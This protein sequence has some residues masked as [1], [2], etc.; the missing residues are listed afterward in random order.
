MRILVLAGGASREREISLRSGKAVASA[1]GSLG[2]EVGMGDP[3][4]SV[5][6]FLPALKLRPDVL[7]NVLH[8]GEGENGVA[9]DACERLGVPYT[10]S[11]PEGSRLGMDKP[12]AKALF[13]EAGLLT[14]DWEAV[15]SCAIDGY[16]PPFPL[17]IVVKPAASG[18]SIGVSIVGSVSLLP[19][20]LGR[21]A[22]ED[23]RVLVEQF[24]PGR[25]ITVGLLDFEPLP[26]VEV[27]PGSE[28][29]DYDAKYSSK[30][31]RYVC[32]APLASEESDQATRAAVAAARA[33]CADGAVRVDMILNENAQVW[34]LEVNT[35]PGM[36]ERSLLP[37]AA[38]AAGLDFPALCARMVDMACKRAGR[39]QGDRRA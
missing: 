27:V 17:P 3:G 15:P 10:G 21:A 5:E 7:F 4:Q 11:G 8:G 9:Q 28:F 24:I 18:S 35:L 30:E 1:L 31:T 34:I 25:E 6:V 33:I 19:A 20:A 38:S 29:Y 26:V 13:R 14:P 12:A 23:E 36:T 39:L 32:P 22:S 2:H 37:L 16:R